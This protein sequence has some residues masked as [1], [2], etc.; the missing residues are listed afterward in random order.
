MHSPEETIYIINVPVTLNPD[1]INK[2]KEDLPSFGSP[3]SEAMIILQGSEEDI[4]CTGLDLQWVADSDPVTFQKD[5]GGFSHLLEKIIDMPCITVA[6]VNG[7]T[8]GGGLGIIT[9][10]DIVLAS[11]KSHFKLSEG[12]L[13][14]IPALILPSLQQRLTTSLIKKMFFSSQDFTAVEAL[15]M[16]LVDAVAQEADFENSVTQ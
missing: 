7:N 5:A 15:S 1:S 3:S 2:L 14:L 13:G 6:V 10:C 9:A 11:S 16:N 12:L 8:V 4:F